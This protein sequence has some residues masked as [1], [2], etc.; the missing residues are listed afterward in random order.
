[1]RV[2]KRAAHT[3]LVAKLCAEL[4]QLLVLCL[5]DVHGAVVH[6]GLEACPQSV[7]WAGVG[8]IET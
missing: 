5:H 8:G 1:M 2:W 7:L 3:Q 4:I 6:V